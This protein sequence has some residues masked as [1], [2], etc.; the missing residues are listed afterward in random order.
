MAHT[1]TN[2]ASTGNR[3]WVSWTSGGTSDVTAS[4]MDVTTRVWDYWTSG[5]TM[6]DT[7]ETINVTAWDN[8]VNSPNGYAGSDFPLEALNVNPAPAP[9]LTPEEIESQRV[10]REAQRERHRIAGKKRAEEMRLAEEKS[11]ALL[12]SQLDEEEKKRL[13]ELQHFFVRS[14]HNKKYKIEKGRYE[15]VVLLGEDGIPIASYCIH[16]WESVPDYDTMLSQKL[17]LETDEAGFLRI[18]NKTNLIYS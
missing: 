10:E 13:D 11:K 5:G 7:S 4:S 9:V 18:A 6:A 12:Q 16:P 2:G 8:G 3:V 14:Q 15:N 1:I 17:M